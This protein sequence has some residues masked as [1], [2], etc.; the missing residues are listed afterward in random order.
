MTEQGQPAKQPWRAAK[1]KRLERFFVRLTPKWRAEF[2]LQK[3]KHHG[4]KSIKKSSNS[5]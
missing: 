4:L 1:P 5:Q 3:A 2:V